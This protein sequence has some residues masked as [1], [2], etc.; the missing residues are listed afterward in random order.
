M[1]QDQKA[2]MADLM[3]LRVAARNTIR[4]QKALR[5]K[6]DILTANRD[7]ETGSAA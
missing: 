4:T 2:T 3:R 6:A 5:K 1:N 7:D